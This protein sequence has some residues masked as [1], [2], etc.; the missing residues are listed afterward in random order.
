MITFW[1]LQRLTILSI[2]NMKISVK[3]NISDM[4]IFLNTPEVSTTQRRYGFFRR[5]SCYMSLTV[6]LV[7]RFGDQ[8]TDL[9]ISVYER[10]TQY[11]D[12]NY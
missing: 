10:V 5:S 2:T 7:E 12:N 4:R 6:Q 11:V 3:V 9:D 1:Y 8:F